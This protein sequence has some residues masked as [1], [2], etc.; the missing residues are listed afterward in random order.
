MNRVRMLLS[1]IGL[2]RLAGQAIAHQALGR[3]NESD[4]V[5]A[6]LIARHADEAE[7]SYQ[8]AEV[9]A[10]RGQ[11]DKSFEWLDRANEQRDPGVPEIKTDP[12]LKKLARRSALR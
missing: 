11:V 1:R 5:L 12:L 6:G 9:Y 10:Y 7:A 2:A 3:E 8:I 4:A